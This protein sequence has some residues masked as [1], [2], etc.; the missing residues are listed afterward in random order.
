MLFQQFINWAAS[1]L[2]N[3]M[4][5]QGYAQNG[6]FY[7]QMGQKKEVLNKEWIVLSKVAPLWGKKEIYYTDYL[8]TTNQVIPDWVVNGHIPGR[9]WNC[10]Y[11]SYHVLV[12]WQGVQYKWLHFGSVVSF[13]NTTKI[14]RNRDLEK[15]L[16]KENSSFPF[17][18]PFCN[19]FP[20]KPIYL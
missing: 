1:H 17:L 15:V 8:T 7:R 4:K 9:G 6:S 16:W 2:A 18:S 13:F 12:C 10:K 5:L 20:K 3:T 14:R 11:I 19:H